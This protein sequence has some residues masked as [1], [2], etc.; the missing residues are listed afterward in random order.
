MK[1]L[2]GRFP[3]TLLLIAML[4]TVPVAMAW[5]CMPNAQLSVDRASYAPGTTV[6]VTGHLFPPNTAVTLTLGSGGAGVGVPQ[7]D[8]AGSFRTSFTLA[9]STP[10]GTN[11]VY[12]YANDPA[13]GGP[14]AGTPKV[15]SFQ[16][17][18]AATQ[19]NQPVSGQA[20]SQPTP[21]FKEPKVGGIAGGQGTATDGS[22]NAVFAGSV[23]P[24]TA[25]AASAS[26]GA[27]TGA[28]ASEG[29]ATSDIWSGFASGKSSSLTSTGSAAIE[30]GGTGSQLGLGIALLAVGLL[31]SAGGIAAA[32]TRR[33]RAP[34]S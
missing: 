21:T 22:G 20:A 31:A 16:V 34:G 29:S 23:G 5:A 7:T 3:K 27:A 1:A 30:D 33:R 6:V 4:V 15:A 8:A 13:T 28:Q 25:G 19:P 9:T 24:I 11:G 32:A 18:A 26:T 17:I 12:A 14:A 10:F 2:A